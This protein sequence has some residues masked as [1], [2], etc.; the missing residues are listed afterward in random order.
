MQAC[1]YTYE[2]AKRNKRDA[3]WYHCKGYKALRVNTVKSNFLWRVLS[4]YFPMHVEFNSG[5]NAGQ[6][7][8]LSINK[9]YSMCMMNE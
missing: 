5:S 7:L 1:M 3:F 8:K 6:F 4:K 2:N 9:L